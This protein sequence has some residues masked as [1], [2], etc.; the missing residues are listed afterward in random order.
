MI[1]PVA[2][3][4]VEFVSAGFFFG[5]SMVPWDNSF[6]GPVGVNEFVSIPG[7]DDLGGLNVLNSV[8]VELRD[9]TIM[10]SGNPG[11]L[12]NTGSEDSLTVEMSGQFVVLEPVSMTVLFEAADD[13]YLVPLPIAPGPGVITPLPAN[14]GFQMLSGLES[15]FTPAN[16]ISA[17][18]V[19][20]PIDGLVELWVD[21][22]PPDTNP[23]GDVQYTWSGEIL[24]TYDYT[25]IPTPSAFVLGGIGL[26][27]AGLARRIRRRKEA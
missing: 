11:V 18:M 17:G 8:T 1:T 25:V 15:A 16:F 24:V 19:D 23:V 20:V 4:D 2:S 10:E 21:L 22:N 12:N 13:N 5:A 27:C 26:V 6:S 14:L 3:A 7:F 9:G